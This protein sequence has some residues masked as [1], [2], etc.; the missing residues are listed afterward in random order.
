LGL[1]ASRFGDVPFKRA[2]FFALGKMMLA[3][4][5]FWAYTSFAQLILIW[6]AN[7]PAEVGWYLVRGNTHWRWL[8]IVTGFGHF[9]IPFACLLSWKFKRSPA[10]IASL[11]AFLLVM[12][13][14]DVSWIVIPALRP[15]G[16]FP[17][18]ADLSSTLI[19]VGAVVAMI[20]LRTRGPLVALDPVLTRA[21]AWE[22]S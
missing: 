5:I 6:I 3:F 9:L 18:L 10:R 8:V 1:F 17:A 21:I 22:D 2:H 16:P 11:S 7:L 12:H 4:I 19:L 14:I 15:Q 13:R 20:A